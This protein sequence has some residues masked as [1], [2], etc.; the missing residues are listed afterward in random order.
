MF[1]LD[2]YSQTSLDGEIRFLGKILGETIREQVG[3][4]M[5]DLEERVRLSARARRNGD[6]EASDALLQRVGSL[7]EAQ[8]RVVTRAFTIF[9]ELA[10]LAE[11]RER[12][13]VLRERERARYPEPRA[14]SILAATLA[15]QA[16]GVGASA[17]Q[18]L[19]DKL[20][21][22]LV[23]TAH[24]T[25][26]KRRSLRAK[27]RLIRNSLAALDNAALLPRE[28][29]RLIGTIRSAMTGLWQME[30]I[31]PRR[32]TVL[33]EVEVGLHFASTLWD[34]VPALYADVRTALDR[35]YPGAALRLGPFL[36]FGSWIGG[37]RDGNPHVTAEITEKALLMMRRAAV[38]SHIARSRQLFQELSSSERE[39][40]ASAELKDAVERYRKALPEVDSILQRVSPREVYRRFLAVVQWKLERTL[41]AD[42]IR[43]L[44]AGAYGKGGEL[45]AD[46]RLMRDSLLANKGERICEGELQR[47]LCQAEVFGLSMA[48]LDIRQES[49]SVERVATEAR[50]G[51][52]QDFGPE[53]ADALRLLRMLAEA[54]AVAGGEALGGFVISMT[55]SLT[56]VLSALWLCRSCALSM[57]IVPLFETIGDLARSPKVMR[58]ML[59]DPTYRD[60][61]TSRGNIQTVMVGYSD[62]TKDGGYLAACWA[63]YKAQSE[64]HAVAAARGVRLVFFH[65]RG[66]ALGRGGG[67]AGRSIQSLPSETLDGGLRI[68]EQGEVLA[69]R[70][71]DPQI[72]YKHLEQIVSATLLAS[73]LPAT[74]PRRGW[75]DAMEEMA[76]L[77]L[78]RYGELVEDPG[79]IPFFERSTPIHEIEALPIASR[80]PRRHGERTLRDL[81]AIPWVFAWTQS[82]CLIPAWYG[83]GSAA[84]VFAES[85]PHAWELLREMYEG[86]P[87]FKA[88]IDNAA[89]ALAKADMPIA[90]MY[91]ELVPDEGAR[92]RIWSEIAKEFSWSVTTVL[93]ITGQSELL[94]DIPWLAQ[95]IGV[96]NPNTDPLNLIQ[97]EWLKRARAYPGADAEAGAL[98]DMLRLTIEGVAC[99]MRTTG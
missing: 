37:D 55:R 17:L 7:T 58:E 29:D 45:V 48:R 46:L 52:K 15:V 67:P 4:E 81:R 51:R 89:L 14:E 36:R 11:D 93:S 85:H 66:G 41:A 86:W 8:A 22:E 19:L 62:S 26:A 20:S 54:T 6:L 71:D 12:V 23:L 68:T 56:D 60:Y 87:F 84:R 32:P 27:V 82:R 47:W 2:M 25:E 65:G 31:R 75:L 18:A 39:R 64:M 76:R 78:E 92:V 3:N 83:V 5:Y 34:V 13:R 24:P 33:E 91:A 99:G 73:A 80:P 95:S 35:A 97:I 1:D 50:D 94:A 53:T 98:R 30:L 57:D 28:R 96:R 44:P 72:A 90:K 40:P 10:N 59:D 21:I 9:F 88:T 63:Q 42:D 74:P 49:R 43:S 77:A 61:L 79:F 70:Y 69:D 16:K 38:E